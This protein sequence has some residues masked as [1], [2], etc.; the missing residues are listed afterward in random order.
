MTEAKLHYIVME[1]VDGGTLEKY[2]S[3]DALLSV[4]HTVEIISKCARVLETDVKV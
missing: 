4:E 2:C 1:Y 3:R